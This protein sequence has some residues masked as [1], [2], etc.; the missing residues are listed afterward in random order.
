MQ[1][2]TS[3]PQANAEVVINENFV[4]VGP[5][6]LY[7]IRQ[8]VT[9]G[10]TWG[11]YGG[12]IG[13]NFV[14]NGTVTLTASST[15]YIVAAP[16]TG[17]VSVSTSTTNWDDSANYIRLYSVVTE[18]STVTSYVDFRQ[19][20]GAG[21]A[22]GGLIG[23]LGALDIAAPNATVNAATL[24]AK[25]ASTNGDLVLSAKG[26]GATQLVR[27]D[28]T[29]TGGDKRGLRAVD[30]QSTRTMAG[31]VATGDRSFA[32]NHD[33]RASGQYSAA[34]GRSNISSG[35]ASLAAGVSTNSSAQTSVALGTSTTASAVQAVAIGEATIANAENSFARGKG[36]TTRGVICS[37]AASSGVLGGATGDCQKRNF[38]LGAFTSNSTFKA[39][40][41]GYAAANTTNQANIA[42]GASAVISA[43]VVA[44]QVTSGNSM[45]W[46]IEGLAQN[47]AGTIS[48]LG[49]PTVTVLGNS[50]ALT[51]DVRLTADST[52]DG[53]AIEGS[54]E[55]A[56]TVYWSAD[57]RIAEVTA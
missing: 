17:A 14:S 33:N 21:G 57:V 50:G 19:A 7:G 5:A 18:V 41:A 24:S 43:I 38:H 1:N 39:L 11:Y 10:L 35:H 31:N 32:A 4:T 8:P 23:F 36:S 34:F 52:N 53:V 37:E 25:T 42:T 30:L 20:Y 55:A 15:N 44:K 13:D 3:P 47:I 46:R 2:I 40:T 29:T 6:A 54:G 49:A 28:G 48:L 45:A 9:T 16:S 22:G 56:S 51:W 26:T 12:Q 27:A